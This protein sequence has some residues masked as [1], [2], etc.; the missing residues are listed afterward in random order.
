MVDEYRPDEPSLVG[1]RLKFERAEEQLSRVE[2][3]LVEYLDTD[4]CDIPDEPE[5]KG[6]WAIIRLRAIRTLPDP[7]W[8]VRIG[9]FL[10]DLRSALDNL[11]WQLVLLNGETPWCKNQFPIYTERAPSQHRL[12]E[13]LRGVRADHRAQIEDLQAYH[14]EHVHV[15]IKAAL[16]WLALLS[17][18]D[19]HR[20]MHP[21]LTVLREGDASAEVLEATP[22]QK[23]KSSGLRVSSTTEPN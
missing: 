12:D 22:E 17:N 14:G 19:K 4:P 18:I 6:E 1:P 16:A 13:M 3:A 11:V 21:I 9:E 23:S 8:G 2:K 20:F 15:Q 10:H 5:R 7:R